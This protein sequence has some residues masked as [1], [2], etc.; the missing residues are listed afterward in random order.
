MKVNVFEFLL[1]KD[2]I[3]LYRV[4]SLRMLILFCHVSLYF[5]RNYFIQTKWIG[6]IKCMEYPLIFHILFPHLSPLPLI[7]FAHLSPLPLILFPHLSP[8]PLILFPHL[9]P[10][11]LTLFP[12]SP[13]FCYRM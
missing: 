2:V 1:V 12:H 3:S 4:P 7:L 13:I 10:L 6:W 8:L 11:T 9:S 5:K